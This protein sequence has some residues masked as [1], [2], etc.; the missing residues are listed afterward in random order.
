MPYAAARTRPLATAQR[1]LPWLVAA[2]FFVLYAG[3]T[4]PS[5]V[6]FFDDTLEFQLVLPT[7]GIAHP[8][9]YPLYTMLGGLWSRLLPLEEWAG[10]ANLFSALCAAAA[11]GMLAALAQRFVRATLPEPGA[12]KTAAAPIWAALAAAAAFGLGPT[13]WAVAT[14]AEVYALHALF[15]ALILLLTLRIGTL[16]AAGRAAGVT[17]VA[18]VVG[19]GLAHHRTTLLLLPAVALYVFWCEPRL[20]RPQRAWGVWALAL[21]AP[22]LIYLWLP[23]RFAMGVRDLNGA[24][25]GGWSG[26]WDH[27]LARRYTAFFAETPLAVARSMGDWAALALHELGWVALLLALIGMTVGLVRAV[28][29][30][31]SWGEPLRAWALLLTALVTNLLFALAYRVGDVEVF[32]LPV[33]LCTAVA[34]GSGAAWLVGLAARPPVGVWGGATAGVL[35]LLLLAS[36]WSGRGAGIDRRADWAAHD[37]ALAMT[38]GNLPSESRVI[39]LEGEVTALRYMQQALD[40]APGV[41]GVVANDEVARRQALDEAMADDAPVFLTRELPG[42]EE[43]YSFTAEGALVRVWP[44]GQAAPAAP[45]MPRDDA[46]A[47][48]ALRLAGVDLEPLSG[49]AGRQL[50]LGLHWEPTRPLEQRLKYSVRVV[51]GAGSVLP[52]ADG[53]PAQSDLYPLRLVSP[54][55]SWLPGER[56]RDE[57]QVALPADRAGAQILLILYDEASLA[58]AG[59]LLLPL[60]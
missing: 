52:L 47:G 16:P 5:I 36:G 40:R 27:V 29:Q 57:V 14:V 20:A 38:A 53:V 22:L 46:F 13:W 42:I 23:L 11:V 37:V 54:T 48:G 39:G 55:T 4:A 3:R 10:R 50:Q 21:V 35:T 59:R 17:W 24:Y 60:P 7:F 19:L 49:S 30:R 58:E 25:T 56:L 18:L 8:T 9:G 51:D 26:F 32:L 28:G 33:W 15:V 12:G 2:A 34:A 41:V 43:A 45:T 6:T 44:R 31:A 1:L